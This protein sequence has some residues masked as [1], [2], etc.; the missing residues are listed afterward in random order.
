[1]A[2]EAVNNAEKQDVVVPEFLK[3]MKGFDENNFKKEIIEIRK[4]EQPAEVNN[5]GA[6]D[7]T[8]VVEKKPGEEGYVE[9]KPEVTPAAEVKPGDKPDEEVVET[10][11]FGK[12][13]LGSDKKPGEEP[14]VLKEFSDIEKYVESNYGVKDVNK[15]L[16]EIVPKWREQAQKGAESEKKY[17]E[18]MTTLDK[19]DEDIVEIMKAN[20][21]GK[22]WRKVI[23]DAPK[24]NFNKKVEDYSKKDLVNHYFPGKFSDEDF[25]DSDEENKSLDIAYE[26]AQKS[27]TNDKTSFDGKRAAMIENQNKQ[28]EAYEKSITSSVEHLQKTLPH[29]NEL[30][31]KETG[32][33]LKSGAQ[34]ILSEFLNDDGTL[35]PDAAQ[36]LAMARHG[37]EALNTYMGIAT[38]KA[39]TE[40]REEFVSKAPDKLQG[41]NGGGE[42]KLSERAKST[43]DM[44]KGIGKKSHY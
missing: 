21:E 18:I 29:L 28:I 17:S 2:E 13:K 16:T 40:I 7:P 20:L 1:M 43:L 41:Q 5:N 32:E 37:L 26:A 30:V 15:A 23:T 39:E 25:T 24:I 27:F 33:A 35:K 44:L 31:V 14:V 36:K 12:K 3:G 9:K 38:R 22:D 11:L 34:G 19:L 4:T 6:G 42:N 10:K 8:P